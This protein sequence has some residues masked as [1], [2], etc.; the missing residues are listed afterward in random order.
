ML[1]YLRVSCSSAPVHFCSCLT[2]CFAKGKAYLMAG[3]SGDIIENTEDNQT[4]MG[5]FWWAL[6]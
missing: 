4:D 3:L 5:Y 2:K 1:S 6:F